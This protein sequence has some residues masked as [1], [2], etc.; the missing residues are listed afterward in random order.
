[1]FVDN[2]SDEQDIDSSIVAAKMNK[3]I[4]MFVM[5]A[6]DDGWSVKKEDDRYIFKKKH[7]NKKE[8]FMESYLEKFILK[9]MKI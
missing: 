8:V 2:C 9:N 7:E 4:M 5:N 1:M 3:R 6:L